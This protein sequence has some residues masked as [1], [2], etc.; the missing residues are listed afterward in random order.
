MTELNAKFLLNLLNNSHV[1]QEKLQMFLNLP[2]LSKSKL[3]K[4]N[5]EDLMKMKKSPQIQKKSQQYQKKSQQYQ[6]L[7]LKM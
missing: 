4:R 5:V 7:N 6:N 3:R 2:K 1:K